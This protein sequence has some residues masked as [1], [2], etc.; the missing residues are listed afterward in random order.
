ML[1]GI[2][3]SVYEWLKSALAR[4]SFLIV[5]GSIDKM[6]NIYPL[7]SRF[8]LPFAFVLAVSL[9]AVSLM[10]MLPG[11]LLHAQTDDDTIEYPENGT[12]PVATFTAI[13]PE[14]ESIVW[15]LAAGT[16]MEDF[17]IENGVLRFKSPP[18]FESPAG[19]GPAGTGTNDNTYVVTIQASDGGLNTTSTEVV[20]IEVTNVEEPGTVTLSTLQ[21]QVGEDITATLT[22]PDTITDLTTITWQWYR[23]NIPIAGGTNGAGE[24]TSIYTPAGGD[25]GSVLRAKAMYDDDKGDDRTAEGDSAHAAREAPTSNIPPS[26]P[27]RD[28][29]MA[30]VQTGQTREVAENTPAGTNIGAP[31]TASDTD[32]LTYSLVDPNTGDAAAFD[33]NRATGRL[34]TKADLDY[35]DDTNQDQSYTVMVRATDPFGADVEAAVTI[36]VTDVNEAPSV[37]GAASVD[38]AESNDTTVIALNPNTYTATDADDDDDAAEVRWSLSG[39]DASKFTFGNEINDTRTLAFKANPDYESPGDSDGNNLYEVTV[40]VTDTKS[41]T[42]ELA[43]MVKVTNIEE[44]GAITFSTLQPRVGFP[45]MATLTDPDNITESSVSWQWYRQATISITD[46]NFDPTNLPG[47]CT[48]TTVTNCSI[49]G[50]TSAA[51]VPVDG[52][53]GN[54]LTAVA[55]YTDGNGD[56]KDYAA[57][58]TGDNNDV[59]VNTINEAPVFP[60]QDA[61]MEG[62]QTAQ[63]RLIGEN[64]PATEL[65][66]N[67]GAPVTAM[68]D[69]DGVLTYSLGGPDAASFGILPNS[70][71]LQTKAV[72][73][74]ETKDTYTVTVTATDSFGVSST[75]TVT[76]KVTNVDEMPELVGEAPEQYAENGTGAV[77][78]FTATDPE[79]KSITWA[80]DGEDA[81]AFSIVN[82]VLRFTSPPDYEA[83]GSQD[84]DNTYEVTIQASDGGADTTAMEN[85]TIEVTN[86]E[87]P[88]TVMLSTLQ[89]QVDQPITATLDDPDNEDA[90]TVE[91][92]W[93]QGNNPIAAAIDGEGTSTSTYIPAPGDVGSVLRATAMYDDGEDED[94]TAREGS[95]RTVRSAPAVNTAPVFPDQDPSTEDVVET[96]QEREVAENT[97]AGTNLGAPVTATDPGDV[98]TYSLDGTGE[99]SFDIDRS[100]GRLITE[101]D[102]DS[103]GVGTYT[104]TVTATDP[105]GSPATSV[106]TITVTNV[107][108]DPMLTAGAVSID[109]AENGTDLDDLTTSTVNEDQFTVTDEDIVDTDA[110][111]KWSLSGPDASKFEFASPAT[112]ATRTLAFKANPDYESP[113]I[114]AGT[115]C[116]K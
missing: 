8:T 26:F 65:V 78:T 116:M 87:E 81:A 72:L 49:K 77:A 98:L 104:V 94:K 28:L 5:E 13:D 83:E 48:E 69:D 15:S 90:S 6:K 114:L 53:V 110:N 99:E 2:P 16:D 62:P 74:K 22:D 58:T 30:G 91:W 93:Y 24:L 59:L 34:I 56:G 79:G 17:S 82:G 46:T 102:L 52:D 41:N 55:T 54:S 115:T 89:P 9:L 106:V 111:L 96:A 43:V 36:E 1:G 7:N 80:L 109:L 105:F 76:I 71:Q 11:G 38:H 64:V 97:P 60:D 33:I 40:V 35:E 32:V 45:V 37:T 10:F 23:G 113:E 88:G 14:G 50:A 61:E 57:T 3:F 4:H 92:Q 100:T 107:N 42:D 67:I 112:G 73:D 12:G 47:E 68:T 19:T 31:V 51:Y 20:T 84:N 70:G 66:R 103:E 39:V 95:Y 21:P 44:M 27:D 18:D 101:A 75:I 25:I 29:D 85:V 86:V 108:E 63:E